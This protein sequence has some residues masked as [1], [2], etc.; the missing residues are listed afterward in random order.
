MAITTYTLPYDI[1]GDPA[2][3]AQLIMVCRAHSGGTDDLGTYPVLIE[4]GATENTIS[5]SFADVL[6]PEQLEHLGL[7]AAAALAGTPSM[8]RR[9][10]SGSF[11]SRFFGPEGGGK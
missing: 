8:W 5:F 6:T 10:G 1:A 4:F 7:S 9:E 2:E 3:M 11:F